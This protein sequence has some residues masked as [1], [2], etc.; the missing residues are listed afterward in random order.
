M[1]ADEEI[2]KKLLEENQKLKKRL[3]SKNSFVLDNLDKFEGLIQTLQSFKSGKKDRY[4]YSRTK[5]GKTQTAFKLNVFVKDLLE[6]KARQNVTEDQVSNRLSMDTSALINYLSTGRQK[7]NKMVHDPIDVGSEKTPSEALPDPAIH[8]VEEVLTTKSAPA[9]R[10]VKI[11]EDSS[12]K[13]D[14][15]GKKKGNARWQKRGDIAPPTFG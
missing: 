1:T 7:R 8:K 15:S 14:N 13:K 9:V 4:F 5:D 3:N 12:V 11:E 6:F 10:S 2:L